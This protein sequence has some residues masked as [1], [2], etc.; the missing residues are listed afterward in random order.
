MS[1]FAVADCL[2]DPACLQRVLEL[3]GEDTQC[4]R[5]EPGLVVRERDRKELGEG[6]TR[7]PGGGETWQTAGHEV[8]VE[9]V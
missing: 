2:D 9:R 8:A 7:W 1:G 5:D 6:R 3:R 4:V